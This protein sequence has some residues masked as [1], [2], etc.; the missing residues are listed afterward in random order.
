MFSS[1]SETEMINQAKLELS[2]E[3]AFNL[4]TAKILSVWERVQSTLHVFLWKVKKFDR[5]TSLNLGSDP[6]ET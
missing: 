6:N 4:V 1:L 5:C 3:N 2:S